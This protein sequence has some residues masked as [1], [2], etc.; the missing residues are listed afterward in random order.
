ML[1]RLHLRL[2]SRLRLRLTRQLSKSRLT[3]H[4]F[5]KDIFNYCIL[6]TPKVLVCVQLYCNLFSKV[7]L[8]LFNAT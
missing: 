6:D 3:A 7:T 5:Q 1:K 4:G 8:E 2:R